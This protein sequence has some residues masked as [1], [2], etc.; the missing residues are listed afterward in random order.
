VVHD[1]FLFVVFL[2]L[3]ASSFRNRAAL[4]A[5][6]LALRHQLIVLQKNPP[7]RLRLQR[8]DRLLW[9]LLSRCGPVGAGVCT[10]FVPRYSD[11]LA[12]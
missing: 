6:N 11:R 1:E 7:P 4:Q 5:E 9:V 2:S 8:S 10:S 12:P 3:V